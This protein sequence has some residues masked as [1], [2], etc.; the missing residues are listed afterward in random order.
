MPMPLS[1]RNGIWIGKS[2]AVMKKQVSKTKRPNQQL[3]SSVM[4][5]SLTDPQFYWNGELHNVHFHLLLL[6]DKTRPMAWQ[7]G[8]TFLLFWNK[9][10]AK[11]FLKFILGSSQKTVLTKPKPD[12]S[13]LILFLVRSKCHSKMDMI[14]IQFVIWYQLSKC[15]LRCHIIIKIQRFKLFISAFGK[16]APYTTWSLQADAYAALK[17]NLNKKNKSA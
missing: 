17:C 8:E 1:L 16:L 6:F 7:T 14:S 3:T 13:Y 12:I 2:A 4:T 10:N 15:Y 11:G 9:L 5:I